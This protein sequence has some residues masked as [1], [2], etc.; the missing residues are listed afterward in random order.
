[1][2]VSN[3]KPY[4]AVLLAA[5]NGMCW[6]EAQLSSILAQQGVNV[7]VFISVDPSSDETLAWCHKYARKDNRVVVL[8][9]DGERFGGAAKNF[10][11]LIR[12]VDFRGFD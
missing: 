7:C 2:P 10:F 12:D 4:V 11:R 9:D 6:I 5:Y 8:A 3:R 1:M